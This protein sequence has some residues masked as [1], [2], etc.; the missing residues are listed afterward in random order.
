L[1]DL[2]F[3]VKK[4]IDSPRRRLSPAL[5]ATPV[6]GSPARKIEGEEEERRERRKG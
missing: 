2:V 1:N 4:R 5:C 3:S 6:F